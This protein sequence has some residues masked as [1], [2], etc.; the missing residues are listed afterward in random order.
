MVSQN[1]G[2]PVRV[3][4]TATGK[5]RPP[6]KMERHHRI[7]KNVCFSPDDRMLATIGNDS[8]QVC[9]WEVAT[10]RQR[11]ELAAHQAS[12]DVIAFSGDGRFLL[13]GTGTSAL[14]WDLRP[15][16]KPLTVD[17][18]R[19]AW[20]DLVSGDAA[21]A[22]Q[23][24]LRLAAAPQQSVPFLTE[25]LPL[26]P[27]ADGERIARLIADLNDDDF[28]T[29]EKASLELERLGEGAVAAL[30]RAVAE[31]SSA[32]VRRRCEVLLRQWDE[33]ALAGELLRTVRAVEALEQA[34]TPEARAL[35]KK[36]ADGADGARLTR[37]A[38]AARERLMK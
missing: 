10:G 22:Y 5:E 28:N 14:V 2:R 35:L 30:R 11:R 7:G 6:L 16:D 9:L 37:E 15:P 32:E 13:T 27:R 12:D 25:A 34:G 26:V 31:D 18:L 8:S 3:W 24:V 23:A 38:K 21:R 29:R 33:P 36:L 20:A 19:A 1:P 4:E 17:A